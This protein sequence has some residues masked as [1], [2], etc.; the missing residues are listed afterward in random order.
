M[1]YIV[2]DSGP[3][4]AEFIAA[5]SKGRYISV[6]T[7]SNSL[8]EYREKLCLLQI[9]IENINAIVDP[10][11]VDVSL[12]AVLFE[13]QNM[14]KIFHSAESDIRLIRTR[15][16]C[17]FRNIFDVMIAAKYL[18]I[19]KCG[20][21][22]LVEEF[23]G[24]KL[25]KR[26][27]KGNWGKRPLPAEMLEYAAM[28]SAY[29]KKIRDIFYGR[30]REKG[31]ED[32]RE[33]FREIETV[34]PQEKRFYENGFWRLQRNFRLSPGSLAVLKELYCAREK[35]AEELNLPPFK[36]LGDE[37]LLKL[38][39]NPA[40]SLKNPRNFKG[41]TNHVLNMHGTWLV[42]TIRRGMTRPDVGI[43]Q[44]EISPEKKAFFEEVKKRLGILKK[45]RSETAKRRN[46][47]SEIIINADIL[48][49]IAFSNPSDEKELKSI[50]HFG[51]DK[52][53]RYGKEIIEALKTCKNPL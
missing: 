45:W 40:E 12:M 48:E 43:R 1:E 22:N 24:V 5:A 10:L 38:S 53:K 3:K 25:N 18:G 35:R 8:Y 44:N 34:E 29:L 9:S 28:D 2:I 31:L 41:I 36:I 15:C 49:R 33:T 26:Y 50:K 17:S 51:E 42:E 27:Q 23:A 7:E 11:A 46:L 16:K 6:D 52:I 37:V 19:K 32:I 14:E 4:F 30:L 47:P 21:D 13:N 20:L 39:L